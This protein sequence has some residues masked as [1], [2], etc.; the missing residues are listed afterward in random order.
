MAERPSQGFLYADSNY[1][2]PQADIGK[3]WWHELERLG[4]EAVRIRLVQIPAPSSHPM[5]IG[6]FDEMK[7][8]FAE[9]WLA[10]SWKRKAAADEARQAEMVKAA[11]ASVDATRSASRAA[12]W[13]AVAAGIAA[14][15]TIA[16]ALLAW[17]ALD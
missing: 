7:R 4:V 17:S 3:Q 16:Q 10:W 5:R 8:G 9:E 11:K 14:V 13:S 15:G 12:L 2:A 6:A 1:P